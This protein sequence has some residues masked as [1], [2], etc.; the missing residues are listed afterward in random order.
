MHRLS[1]NLMCTSALLLSLCTLPRVAAATPNPT[2]ATLVSEH[3]QVMTDLERHHLAM[4][5]VS[6]RL[7]VAAH[8][9]GP[10]T[11]LAFSPDGSLVA[12]A[13]NNESAG[14]GTDDHSIKLWS[15]RTGQVVATLKGRRNPVHSIAFSP[16]GRLLASASADGTIHLWNVNRHRLWMVLRASKRSLNAVAFD[17]HGRT[18]VSGGDDQAVRFWSLYPA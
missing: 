5:R 10:V 1:V 15:V 12:T 16:N 4:R 6:A 8:H 7:V 14:L 2:S 3:A 18:L 13:S 11:S 9:A 17:P